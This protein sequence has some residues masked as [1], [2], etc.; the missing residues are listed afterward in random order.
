MSQGDAR[1]YDRIAPIYDLMEAPM[2][3][4][5]GR[6]RRARV[7]NGAHGDVLEIGVGTGRNLE[8]YPPDA[9]VT[10]ID[11]SERMLERARA[12]ASSLER[13]PE[14]RVADAESLPFEDDRFDTVTATCVFC[15]VDDPVRGLE[16][17]RRVVKPD[18]E[19]RLLEHV[20]PRNPVLG[21]I[22]DWLTP[23]T[24]RLMGPE[25]NRRTETNVEA[26]GLEIADV[27]RDGIW[28]EIVAKPSG[29]PAASRR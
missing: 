8:L 20:R 11:I 28:R 22:F 10:G 9:D 24:R 27:R 29:G 17:V 18:G 26:A 15:S 6:D 16:E 7:I 1:A 2:E 3:W 12:R 13:S 4:L 23:L 21:K 5:G 25:I 19:V 14:L